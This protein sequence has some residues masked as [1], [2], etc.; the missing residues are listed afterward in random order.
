M[1]HNRS[2]QSIQGA[3]YPKGEISRVSFTEKSSMSGIELF[4]NAQK[5]LGR[6]TKKQMK[7]VL[8]VILKY[9]IWNV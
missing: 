2:Y 4:H 9:K 7:E 6:N 8:L 5:I 1:Y 3:F